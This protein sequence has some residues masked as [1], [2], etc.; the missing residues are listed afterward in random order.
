MLMVCLYVDAVV[1]KVLRPI[2][3]VMPSMDSKA[4]H[5]ELSALSL[6]QCDELI[7]MVAASGMNLAS[8]I[9]FVSAGTIVK[10]LSEVWSQ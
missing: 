7:V 5:Q 4:G 10:R 6:M 2:V 3:L 8:Y 9:Q 1:C